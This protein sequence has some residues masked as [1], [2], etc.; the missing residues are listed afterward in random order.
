MNRANQSAPGTAMLVT[1]AVFA[2]VAAFPAEPAAAQRVAVRPRP[3]FLF[4]ADFS[5]D[6][7]Q[8]ITGGDAVRVH[9]TK[10]GKL[11]QEVATEGYARKVRFSPIA[12]DLFAAAGDK[13]VVRIRQTSGD[14]V[15]RELTGHKVQV[16]TMEFAPGGRFLATGGVNFLQGKAG[17]G[18]FKL[19]NI[20]T[21]QELQS[22]EFDKVGVYAT[23]FSADSRRVAFARNTP[24]DPSFIDVY[25]IRPWKKI[26]TVSFRPGFASALEFT[27]DGRGLLIAGGVCVRL[28]EDSC[29]PTGKLWRVSF[30]ESKATSEATLLETPQSDYFQTLGLLT[31]GRRFVTGTSI[32]NPV[33]NANGR[34]IGQQMIAQVQMRKLSNGEVLW[35]TNGGIG[36]PYGVCVSPKGDTVAAC[37]AG[38]LLLFEADT[39]K[40]R[41]RIKVQPVQPKAAQAGG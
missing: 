2:A 10:A 7:S 5:F 26:H 25:Q 32:L 21:G 17:T 15:L 20:E 14:K 27:N 16:L 39:G 37:S 13:G 18:E 35:G 19:W 24:E 6:G 34:R 11:L 1:V 30:D 33:L 36:R 23:A 12:R 8:V 29:Q 28:N 4:A 40:I 22:L 38:E 3:V 9:E 31:D 41:Q